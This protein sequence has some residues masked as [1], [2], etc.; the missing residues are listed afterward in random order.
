MHDLIEVHENRL[1]LHWIPSH[2][3]I[4]GNEEA[5]KLAKLGALQSYS[6]ARDF[7]DFNGINSIS[8]TSAKQQIKKAINVITLEYWQ[9]VNTTYSNY[10]TTLQPT[11]YRELG[12]PF[13]IKFRAQMLLGCDLLNYTR[14]RFGRGARTSFCPY[15]KTKEE[16][17]DHFLTK[18][19]LYT[20][21]RTPLYRAFIGVYQHQ[22]RPFNHIGLMREPTS[23]F[24]VRRHKPVIVALNTFLG[25]AWQTRQDFLRS[26]PPQNVP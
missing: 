2:C 16:T 4:Y 15:C 3:G 20:E 11:P 13:Q 14:H 21:H 19:S 23:K 1:I 10:K 22:E 25:K 7:P 9:T 6:V 8:I 18:C 5:D 17:V 24:L 12:T 26:P